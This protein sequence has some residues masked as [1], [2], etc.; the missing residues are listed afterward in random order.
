MRTSLKSQQLRNL[1]AELRLHHLA[2]TLPEQLTLVQ[3]QKPPYAEWLLK[4]L[5]AEMNARN[6]RKKERQ[7]K[8]ARIPLPPPPRSF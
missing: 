8:K 6:E 4:L 7:L 2:A 5:E 3:S 1:L